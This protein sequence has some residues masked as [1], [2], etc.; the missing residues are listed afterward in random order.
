MKLQGPTGRH[1]RP[2][3]ATKEDFFASVLRSS[4]T[5]PVRDTARSRRQSRVS[6]EI[7][8]SNQG[9]IVPLVPAYCLVTGR[10]IRQ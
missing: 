4:G 7:V 1:N 6:R 10:R 5:S 8:S 3:D 2:D 9:N